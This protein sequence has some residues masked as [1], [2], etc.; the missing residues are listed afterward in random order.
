MVDREVS[1]F[2][3]VLL[4]GKLRPHPRLSK[5]ADT[6]GVYIKIVKDLPKPDIEMIV[7]GGQIIMPL[8]QKILL[9]GS[10]IAGGSYLLYS[11]IMKVLDQTD[12]ISGAGVAGAMLL[13]LGPLAALGGFAFRQYSAYNVAKQKFTLQ[14]SESQYFQTIDNNLGS[15]TRLLDEAEEQECREVL[16]G[17]YFLWKYAPEGATEEA[18]DDMIEQYIEE[19]TGL[20]VDFEIGDSLAKLV[21]LNM[22][23][24]VEGHQGSVLSEGVG[25]ETGTRYVAEPIE[26]ALEALDYRWDN[27]FTYNQ[28]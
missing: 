1:L 6:D 25:L 27:Y 12:K 23:R 17:Y 7:P 26:K 14:V 5:L 16:L 10:M 18:L 15:I 21:K 4:V 28:S 2:K 22:V 24:T 13:L 9:Y 8:I 20:K 19:K 11:V 3:R